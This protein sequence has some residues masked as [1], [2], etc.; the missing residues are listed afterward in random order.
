MDGLLRR[1]QLREIFGRD[2]QIFD[3]FP[4]IIVIARTA[5]MLAM[6]LRACSIVDCICNRSWRSGSRSW[7]IV[8]C[9]LALDHSLRQ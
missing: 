8:E 2:A 9:L 5:A 6:R 7:S 4:N 1:P 3:R